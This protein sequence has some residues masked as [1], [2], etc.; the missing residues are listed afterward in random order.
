MSIEEPG[1]ALEDP[2]TFPDEVWELV[3]SAQGT[4][5][6]LRYAELLVAEGEVRGLIGPRELPRL[7]SRHL[8]N[9]LVVNPLI[10]E[11]VTVADVGSGAGLPGVVIAAT[12]P[13]VAV[14]LI[15]PMER[16]A[17]WLGEVVEDLG[18]ENARVLNARAEDLVGEVRADVV[19]ARA[20]ARLDKLIPWT[21]PLAARG[22]RVLALKGERAVEEIAAA[23]K[24]FRKYRIE[25]SR[26]HELRSPLDGEVTRV[27]ELQLAR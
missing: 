16:R 1:V 5:R 19:T 7:W 11:G 23:R 8:V 6:L 9:C 2:S 18:L 3:G 20:V 26:L 17:Q 12:R 21:V 4:A 10:G 27:V 22:G 15:E 24:L 14:T 25:N 13:D